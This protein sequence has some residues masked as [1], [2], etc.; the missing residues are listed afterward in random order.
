MILLVKKKKLLVLLGAGASVEQGMPSVKCLNEA[1]TKWAADYAASRRSGQ[2]ARYAKFTGADFYRLL[3][4]NRENYNAGL[5]AEH[6]AVVDARTAPNFERVM[7]DLHL[8]MNA[9]LAR[10]CG[11]PFL[12]FLAG[13]KAFGDLQIEPDCEQT[14]ATKSRTAYLAVENQLGHLYEKLARYVRAASIRFEERLASNVRDQNFDRCR[15]LLGGLSSAFDVGIYNLNYDTVALNALPS[16][17]VGFDRSSGAFCAPEVH[18]RD[19]WNF[20][21]HL[22]GSVH[23]DITQPSNYMRDANFG[24]QIVWRDKL[25]GQRGDVRDLITRSDGKRML[26]TSLVAGGWK[27]DQL[28]LEPYLSFYS[29]LPRHA[30]MADAIVIAGY[31]FGDSHVNSVLENVLRA[32]SVSGER[33]PV[34]VLDYDASKQV[35]AKRNDAWISGLERTL[36]VSRAT[37]CSANHSSQPHWMELPAAHPEAVFEKAIDDAAAV[38]V[39]TGG[40]CASAE[41]LTQITDWLGGSR[42]AF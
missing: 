16:S 11:D 31:G 42:T 38:G 37:F 10:P 40:F 19:P 5:N 23:H 7:G 18:Q 25:D 17:F 22:H 15:K 2:D 24:R 8:L 20:I 41:K 4:E 12:R 36:R 14:D 30:Y 35:L 29:N 26:M 3:H 33:P 34:V 6:C 27:L 1:V 39:W 32:K 28:Q 21:Y 13:G 9:V